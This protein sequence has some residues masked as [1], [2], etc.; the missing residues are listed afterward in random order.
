MVWRGRLGEESASRIDVDD[1]GILHELPDRKLA[2]L[3]RSNANV[4]L[5]DRFIGAFSD[6]MIRIDADRTGET[7]TGRR[8]FP[9]ESLDGYSPRV[10]LVWVLREGPGK[11]LL[12]DPFRGR[13]ATM[14]GASGTVSP[15]VVVADASIDR[16]LEKSRKYLAAVSGPSAPVDQK[17][18]RPVMPMVISFACPSVAGR[19]WIGT[20]P[21]TE[22]EQLLLDADA[23]G[24]VVRRAL[25]KLHGG[26]I[27][28]DKAPMILTSDRTRVYLGY[29][30]GRVYSYLPE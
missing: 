15:P 16:A 20:M 12:V 10:S 14:D 18:R 26:T 9:A 23:S 22:S 25:C 21:R 5:G 28:K 11:A 19:A 4:Y 7:P 3:P 8:A 6:G 29:W 1:V 27:S 17:H 30:G 2:E 24:R 13:I